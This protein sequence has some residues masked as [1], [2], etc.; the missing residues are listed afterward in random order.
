MRAASPLV[1]PLNPTTLPSRDRRERSPT[2]DVFESVDVQYVPSQL[3]INFA[4]LFNN[5]PRSAAEPR[6]TTL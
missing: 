5:I 2:V 4:T 3:R 1:T 6:T